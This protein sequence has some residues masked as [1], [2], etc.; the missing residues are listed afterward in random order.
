MVATRLSQMN[1]N[2]LAHAVRIA[3]S[4]RSDFYD[5][6][7]HHVGDAVLSAAL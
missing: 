1:Q 4:G 6:V 3:F 2:Q 5:F 7:D